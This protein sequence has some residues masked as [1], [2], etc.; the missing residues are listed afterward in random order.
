M[1]IRLKMLPENAFPSP[2]L[3]L[4]H[5]QLLHQAFCPQGV[6]Q[7]SMIT[8]IDNSIRIIPIFS[9][10]PSSFDP[11][12]FESRSPHKF[13]FRIEGKGGKWGKPSIFGK[14]IKYFETGNALSFYQSGMHRI[15]VSISAKFYQ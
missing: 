7:E 2:W 9:G 6:L 10:S 1:A 12:M 8:I 4:W 15:E 3:S 13:Y 11:K 14:K 5:R